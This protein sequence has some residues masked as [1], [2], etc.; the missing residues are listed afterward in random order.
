MPKVTIMPNGTTF[1][2]RE[3]ES[4]LQ[5]GLN[6]GVALDYGCSNGNCGDCLAKLVSGDIGKIR[7][8]DFP[9]SED[10]KSE[11]YFPMCCYQAESDIV[12]EADEASKA[13]E[14]CSASFGLN[15]IVTLTLLSDH[16]F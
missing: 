14:I 11:A 12:L 5:A 3:Y 8:F 2:A 10:M 15:C 16:H 4:I 7:H 13:S 6:A 9:V 1:E